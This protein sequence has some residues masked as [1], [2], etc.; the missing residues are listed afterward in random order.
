MSVLFPNIEALH[1]YE[2]QIANDP[3]NFARCIEHLN[4]APDWNEEYLRLL[5]LRTVRNAKPPQ[6]EPSNLEGRQALRWLIYCE[7][8]DFLK[9][10]RHEIEQYRKKLQA[11]GIPPEKFFLHPY[12]SPSQRRMEREKTIFIKHCVRF[13]EPIPWDNFRR[14]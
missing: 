9:R 7:A 2:H 6:W 3:R 11:R 5:A 14:R 1:R 10:R 8:L 13:G 4:A 12:Q